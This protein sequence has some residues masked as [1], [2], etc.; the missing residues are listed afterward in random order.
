M[1]VGVFI[2]YGLGTARD[3]TS[4]LSMLPHGLFVMAALTALLQPEFNLGEVIAR[5]YVATCEIHQYS[6]YL[7][8]NPFE[9]YFREPFFRN[10]P[11]NQVRTIIA[12]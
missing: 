5:V 9:G 10:I 11:L 12:S 1:T 2:L 7:K 6:L 8:W 3:K 4:P